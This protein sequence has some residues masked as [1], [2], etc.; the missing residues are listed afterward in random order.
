MDRRV[1]RIGREEGDGL[2][3]IRLRALRDAPGAFASSFEIESAR[4]RA[5]WEEA[6]G[7]W[8]AGVGAA[9][10]VAELDHEWVGLIG[11]FRAAD[12][13]EI[14]ELV[15]MWVAPGFRRRGIAQSLVEEV[16][17]WARET[18]ADAVALGVADG[19]DAAIAAYERAGFV[20][21]GERHPL[22]SDPSRDEL[23]M[24]LALK[25]ANGRPQQRRSGTRK[26]PSAG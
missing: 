10:F 12:R 16:V 26:R 2:R 21:T 3:D 24:I 9:T 18:G 15:S 13:R 17:V 11:A 1:R 4:P 20:L 7:A 22:P 6:A 19:N 8:S 14:V 5:A 25:G 23:R